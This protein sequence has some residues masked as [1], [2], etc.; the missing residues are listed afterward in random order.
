MQVGRL[1]ALT[2][3]DVYDNQM[4]GD[5]PSTIAGLTNLKTLHLDNQHLKPVRMRYC[6]H[7][8]PN[9]GKY[10]WRVVRDEYLHWTATICPDTHIHDTDFTFNN[11]QSSQSWHAAS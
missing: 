2:E 3:L 1:H 10:N 7:R 6:G 11:L 5:V 4:S 9:T 8:I